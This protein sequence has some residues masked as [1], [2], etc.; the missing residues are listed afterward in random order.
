M[1][2][3][4][5][6]ARATIRD[7]AAAAGV[8]PTTVSHALNGKG[9]VD[10]ATR[11]RVVAAAD[12]L[13]YRPSRAARALRAGR[14]GTVALLLPEIQ[15]DDGEQPAL[16]LDYYMRLAAAAA[17]AA[18]AR[19]HPLLLAP[20]PRTPGELADL[21]V[22]GAIVVDPGT[23]DPRIGLLLRAGLPV[24]SIERDLGRPEH[25]AYVHGENAATV[26]GLLDHLAGAGATR[27]AMLGTAADWAWAHESEDAYRAWCA[28][29]GARPVL[30]R[31]ALD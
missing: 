2:S 7:V 9:S 17:R 20:A 27:I 12:E 24:V 18:A 10:P 31:T 14:T 29:R 23:E 4:P 1:S 26:R 15:P 25:R 21:G 5:P 30:A 19:R 16:A 22:D 8:S 13:G 28:E 6:R 3:S 11:D